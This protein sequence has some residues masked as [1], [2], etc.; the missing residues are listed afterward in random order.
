[1]SVAEFNGSEV[2]DFLRL[3]FA[4]VT[5]GSDFI[6]SASL[7]HKKVY[8]E[9]CNEMYIKKIESAR[10]FEHKSNENRGVINS[11]FAHHVLSFCHMYCPDESWWPGELDMMHGR[12]CVRIQKVK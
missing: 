1:M 7:Y 8:E 12:R 3:K 2:I 4:W 5:Y 6:K 10:R 11:T 9:K